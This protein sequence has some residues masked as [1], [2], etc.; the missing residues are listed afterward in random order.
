MNR[1]ILIPITDADIPQVMRWM[2][3]PHVKQWFEHPDEW[4]YEMQHRHDE[5]AFIRHFIAMYGLT[6]IGFCQYYDYFYA[7][8]ASYPITVPQ[9]A[10]SIDYLIGEEAYLRQGLGK[11]MIRLLIERIKALGGKEVLSDPM[12]EN[13]ISQRTLRSVGFRRITD[14]L[15]GMRLEESD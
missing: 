8:E 5:F 4:L 2:D 3:K 14:E 15:H 11:A 10:Y 1:I 12:P 6:K 13:E 9:Y 7:Q